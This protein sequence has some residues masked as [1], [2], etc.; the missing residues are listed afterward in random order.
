MTI[1]INRLNN[2]DIKALSKMEGEH[3]VQLLQQQVVYHFYTEVCTCY[4]QVCTCY[5]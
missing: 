3:F 1:L 5:S 4:T 2:D